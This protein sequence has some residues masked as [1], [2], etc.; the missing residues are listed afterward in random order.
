ML[1]VSI[2]L[3]FI[4]ILNQTI[5][6]TICESDHEHRQMRRGDRGKLYPRNLKWNRRILPSRMIESHEHQLGKR[7]PR[8]DQDQ[9]EVSPSR[10]LLSPSATEQVEHDQMVVIPMAMT[11]GEGKSEGVIQGMDH[12]DFSDDLKSQPSEEAGEIINSE[13][14]RVDD[15]RT[16]SQDML[17]DSTHHGGGGGHGG[18]LDMGAYSGKKGA[19]GWYAD[20]PVG[21]G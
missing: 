6:L 8:E 13:E 7:N 4:L 2:T 15:P 10:E 16:G 11:A 1:Q 9:E 21:Y 14:S 20:F 17:A 18:W 5:F 19:F 3:F 12:H